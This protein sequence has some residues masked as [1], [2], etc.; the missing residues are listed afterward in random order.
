MAEAPD[1]VV[2][3][4]A[5][6]VEG[7]EVKEIY[8]FLNSLEY[9]SADGVADMVSLTLANPE[10]IL[11]K[12]K[13]FQPYNEIAIWMGYGNPTFIGK[14]I[15]T[16]PKITFPPDGM[17]IISIKG[18]TKDWVMM[19]SD[20]ADKSRRE[21]QSAAAVKSGNKKLAKAIKRINYKD[22]PIDE[23]V[24]SIASENFL[25]SDVDPVDI[26]EIANLDRPADVTDYDFI[27]ALSN[28]TGFY[29][30][31]DADKKGVWTLHFR[32]PNKPLA[33]QDKI[34][35][36]KYNQGDLST[37][38]S[39]EPEVTFTDKYTEVKAQAYAN[40]FSHEGGQWGTIMEQEFVIDDAGTTPDIVFDGDAKGELKSTLEDAESVQVYVGD[41][42]FKVIPV[43]HINSPEKLKAFVTAWF[44]TNRNNFIQGHGQ[45]VGL[46]TL[47]AR[48]THIIDGLGLPFD[49]EYYF[50]KVKHIF[51]DNG[52]TC[53]FHARKVVG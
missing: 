12:S 1:N 36:F 19:K 37:L 47:M 40:K 4:Y 2:P 17:P 27:K 43:A 21:Q 31:V 39:F 49:G 34:Y 13:I 41:F 44:Q 7:V 29:F 35:T 16:R 50:S 5:I 23:V 52:Y 15:I 28:I 33:N 51:N 3:I 10:F 38:M 45:V 18:Y 48:Q 11:S 24:K 9:E 30:W 32:D 42:S 6:E 14:C 8:P 26:K 20:P 22:M 53:D 46:E 25:R